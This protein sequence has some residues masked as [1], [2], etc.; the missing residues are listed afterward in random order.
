MLFLKTFGG[1]SVDV[2]GAS[3]AGAGRQRKT[4][5]LLALLSAAGDR[6][7][8]RDKLVAY[9]W[10][11]SD[12]EHGRNLLKQACFA[13]RRDLRAPELFVG[14]LLELRLRPTTIASDIRDFERALDHGDP[15]RAVALYTGPFLDGFYLSGA[16]EFERWVEE[17]RARLLLRTSEAL[18][19]LAAHAEGTGD[20]RAC[21]QWWRRLTALDPFSARAALGLMH[22]L[23][24]VGERAEAVEHGRRY[25]VFVRLEL[26]AEPAS[27]VASLMDQLRHRTSAG[28]RTPERAAG[29]KPARA[30]PGGER[31]VSTAPGREGSP[32]ALTVALM[33]A[34]GAG[35]A[36]IGGVA[37]F[38][39]LRSR[40][41]LDPN[42]VAVAP[43]D[44]LAPEVELWREGFV[45]VLAR[46]LDGAGPLRTVAPTV[47]IRRWRG[48]ADPIAASDLGRR[49]GARLVLFGAILGAGRDSIRLNATLYDVRTGRSL[50]EIQYWD[51]TAHM[52]RLSDSLTVAVLRELGRTRPIA[53]V[54]LAAFGSTSLPAVKAFLQGEQLL[55]RFSLDSAVRAY[56]DAVQRDSMF[57][58]ALSRL[59]LVRGWRGQSGSPLGL[60]A[61]RFNHGLAPR[62]SLLIVADSLEAASDD[63]LDTRYWSHRIRKF[64][65]LEEA[66]RRYPE[67]PQVW[68]ALGEA[69]FHLGYVVGSTARQTVDAFDRAI[70]LDTAFAPAYFHPVQ[71]ALDRDDPAAAQRYVDRYLGL[72][73][74]VPEGAGIRLVHEL[75]DPAQSGSPRLQSVLDR[76]SA[77]VLF[78]AWRTVHSWPD[79]AEAGVRLLRLLNTGRSGTGNSADTVR[80]RYL[81]ATELLFRGH[82]RA[83]RAMVGSRFSMPFAELAALGII[84]PDTASAV[85]NRWLLTN[86]EEVVVA[87]RPWVA[88]CYRSF[89]AAEW[90]ARKQDTVA[91][92]TLMRRGDSIGR[93]AT[94]GRL[95][96]ARADVALA[97]GALA[98]ARR[99]TTEAL[100]GFLAFPDSLCSGRYTSLYP[101]LAPLTMV[102][103]RLLATRGH[104]RDA[105][106]LFDQQVALPLT[107]SAVMGTLER[108]HIAERLGDRPTAVRYYRFVA[109]AWLHADPELQPIVAEA[110]AAIARLNGDTQR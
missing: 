43:F 76:A 10:P 90:W 85:F 28:R 64:E 61:G 3:A 103:V 92:L 6:G 36:T 57:A 47:V 30:E 79:S 50:M 56:E 59:G 46:N 26:G 13:L 23:D 45:D 35:L 84:P 48:R 11:D 4:L 73:S 42:L 93:S 66:S 32:R 81:L 19:A 86:N 25:E 62:D 87:D 7:V 98:L 71:L 95:G 72:T 106:R 34:V 37:A 78:D 12:E 9:L 33:V 96:D 88:R 58:L 107:A 8:S 31:P 29:N 15:A 104:D 60:Q 21:V 80:T 2:D 77:N 69:R 108:A 16:E 82:L 44:V 65:T 27:E 55:R 38:S 49:T 110:R 18:A 102:R 83:A 53:G 51:A 22:A 24:A 94:L 52:D 70:A 68:Y 97:Q 105:A 67:D 5:A 20:V 75:L 63:S 74:Q 54:H 40:D 99:D 109:R 101:S 14:T 89:L 100:R 39:L 91:L 17:Q 41:R 1:L